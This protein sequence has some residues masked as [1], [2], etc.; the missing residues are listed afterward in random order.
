MGSKEGRLKKNDYTF[1]PNDLGCQYSLMIDY[2]YTLYTTRN[3]GGIGFT[4]WNSDVMPIHTI[5]R[6][7]YRDSHFSWYMPTN[8][9]NAVEPTYTRLYYARTNNLFIGYYGHGTEY[10]GTDLTFLFGHN[11][12]DYEIK[13][14]MS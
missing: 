7:S 5:K 6:K 10:H 12:G 3:R 4:S 11:V 2:Y 13:G 1:Y 9:V 14:S 8:F